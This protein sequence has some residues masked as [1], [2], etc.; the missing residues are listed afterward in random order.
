MKNK[1]KSISCKLRFEILKRDCFTC[2]YCGLKGPDVPID[3]FRIDHINPVV[4]GGDNNILNLV[5]SCFDCNAGK[6]PVPLSDNAVIKTQRK[7]LEDLEERRQQLEAMAEWYESLRD[8]NKLKTIKAIEY[9]NASLPRSLTD[10]EQEGIV[11]EMVRYELEDILKAINSSLPYYKKVVKEDY[12]AVTKREIDEESYLKETLVPLFLK[13]LPGVLKIEK[14]KREDPEYP[15]LL[16]TY[17]KIK[18][19]MRDYFFGWKIMESFYKKF[20]K[21]GFSSNRCVEIMTLTAHQDA[22]KFKLEMNRL[23][24]RAETINA[25]TKES[26]HV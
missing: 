2:Q 15:F 1:R 14:R 8:I 16:E 17:Q 9:L 5:T 21:M 26:I 6:G 19:S 7:Q 4:K 12:R 3:V 11:L 10:W 24:R 18:K 22:E 13:K 23:L 25:K 20:R